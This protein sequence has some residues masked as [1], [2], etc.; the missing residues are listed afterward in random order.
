MNIEVV[1]TLI[2]R[3]LGLVMVLLGLFIML[4]LLFSFLAIESM[5]MWHD[6]YI[7]LNESI[8]WG[9]FFIIAGTI[10]IVCSNALGRLLV[11]GL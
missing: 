11:K 6:T 4:S 3:V 9:G 7:V 8:I 1:G 5:P 2:I 10:M